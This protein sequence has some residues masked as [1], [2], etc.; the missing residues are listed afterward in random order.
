MLDNCLHH[1]QCNTL[2]KFKIPDK[3]KKIKIKE[4]R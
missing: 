1:M 2:T 4:Q 3:G